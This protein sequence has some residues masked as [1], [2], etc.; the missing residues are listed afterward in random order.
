MAFMGNR[1]EALNMT[2]FGGEMKE[3]IGMTAPASE[4]KRGVVW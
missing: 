3:K 1:K 4:G 2:V